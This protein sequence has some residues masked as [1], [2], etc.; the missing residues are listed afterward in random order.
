MIDYGDES[1]GIPKRQKVL[2]KSNYLLGLQC[3]KLLWVKT[4]DK[5][6]IPD[7]DEFAMY[8]FGVGDE[9]EKIAKSIFSG[10]IEIPHEDFLENLRLSEEY[11]KERIP[12][13]EPSFKFGQLFSRAD[14]LVPIGED[15]WDIVEIK[16][17]TK[18]KEI[19]VH[20]VS[21]QKYIYENCG[22]KIRKCFLMHINRAYIRKEE[23]EP[24]KFFTLSDISSEVKNISEKLEERIAKMLEIINSEK[25][26]G[27]EIGGHCS[28]PYECPMKKECWADLPGGNILEFYRKMR[29]QTFN[30][31]NEGQIKI[32]K[33][34]DYFKKNF[35]PFQKQVLATK[36]GEGYEN[37]VLGKFLDSLKYPIYYLDLQTINPALPKFKF[38]K[39]YKKIPYQFSLHIQKSK[40]SSV[41]HVSF[42][43]DGKSDPRLLFL[44]ILKENLGDSG[45]ILVYDKTKDGGILKDLAWNFPM[46]RG[47]IEK[48]VLNRIKDLWGLFENF[49]FFDVEDKIP[50]S[51][52][53][54]IPKFGELKHEDLEIED[55]ETRGLL[56][57]KFVHSGLEDEGVVEIKKHLR[58]KSR[59]ETLS[60][61]NV[62][63]VLWRILEG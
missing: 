30:L 29:I 38:M 19:N 45:T 32:N 27:Y 11:L 41:E 8:R 54:R 37:R 52:K 9:M 28:N 31:G 58:K 18:V 33:V 2:T 57:E 55:S 62:I 10:G 47:W 21:F 42:L 17:A 63:D 35:N 43:S 5:T 56:Y 22:L 49:H 50:L 14:V 60:M 3:A 44:Q 20:D 12:L 26:P 7:P 39:P 24:E 51:I 15:E 34:S 16:S 36:E 13:F 59:E 53:Y 1:S 23:I 25:E 6:R 48:S 4:H 40:V 46:H 61:I